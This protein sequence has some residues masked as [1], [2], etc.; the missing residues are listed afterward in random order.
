[1]DAFWQEDW[2]LISTNV[3]TSILTRK[4]TIAAGNSH[5][6]VKNEKRPVFEGLIAKAGKLKGFLFGINGTLL[7]KLETEIPSAGYQR[8][9]IP[10]V[11]RGRMAS[12]SPRILILAAPDGM[13][14]TGKVAAILFF[15]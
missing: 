13:E 7:G 5:W 6:M 3:I 8:I 1:M 2:K 10:S 15:P 11:P 12:I 14:L 9:E 4:L